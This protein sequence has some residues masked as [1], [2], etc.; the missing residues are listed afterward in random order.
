MDNQAVIKELQ[1]IQSFA[2]G[3]ADKAGKLILELQ[4]VSTGRSKKNYLSPDQ[5]ANILARRKKHL[6]QKV[7]KISNI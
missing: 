3:L 4:P 1:T 7:S 2:T 5:S 6:S